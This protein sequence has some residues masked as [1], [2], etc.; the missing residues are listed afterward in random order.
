MRKFYFLALTFLLVMGYQTKAQNS[1]SF[2]CPRDTLITDCSAACIILK[3]RIPDVRSSTNSYVINPISGAPGGCYAPY[4]DPGLPGTPTSLTVDD[5]YSGVINLP[6]SFPFYGANYS[7]LVASTNGYISFDAT[8]A[9][10]FSHYSTAAGDLPNTGYDRALIMGPYHDLDPAYTTS[11]TQRI[12]YEVVGTAPHRKWILSFYKVPLFLTSC[13]NLIENTHQIVIYEGLG[14]AEVFITSKQICTGWN[15]G[16]AM[17]GMQNYNRNAAIM[18]P[19]RRVSDP[20][21]GSVNMNESWRFVP[22]SGPT[23]YRKVELFD[24][25]GTLVSTGDTTSIGNSTFEVAFP[26]VCPTTTTTYIVKSTYQ[27]ISNPNGFV[28]G[29]DTIRVVRSNAINTPAVVTNIKC[30]GGTDGAFTITPSGSAGPFNYSLNAGVT[31][32]AGNV[33][34][35]LSAGAYPVRIKDLTSGCIR[36]TVITITE[37]LVLDATAAI[38]NATC[39][40]TPNGSIT[41]NATGGTVAYTYSSDGTT[42]GTNNVFTVTDGTYTINI[43]DANGCSKTLTGVVVPL[44]NDLTVQTR[45]DTTICIG[46]TIQLTTVSNAASYSWSPAGSLN[47][48]TIA[49]PSANPT[50]NTQYTVTAVLGQCTKTDVVDIS[51]KQAVTVNAGPDVSII[52]G[53]FTQLFGNVT[54]ASSYLWTPADGLSSTTILAPIAKPITTTTYILT[55]KNDVGCTAFDDV[56]VTVIPYCIKVKNAFTPNGDGINDLWK[57][58]DQFDCLKNVSVHVFNRYGNPVFESK[59]YHNT[60]DGRYKGKSVPDGTYYAVIDFLLVNGKTATVKTDLTILR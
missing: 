57:V 50:V 24:L 46:A 6:F 32:Q 39:S 35:G 30:N 55:V 12:K 52:S 47:N 8:R 34:T 19:N 38:V 37:P 21:W 56:K 48:S 31:Y 33:F 53:D 27:D 28:F 22:A 25:A 42:Y 43:K 18:A 10:L 20:P 29:T 9:G 59:D 51:V 7:S 49:S 54:G 26:N 16:K 11:P 36:D 3:S 17:V 60:W 13:N 5:T 15:N 44:T 2:A 23:L 4:V 1:F 45:S 14:I 41:V 40:A 58:Y